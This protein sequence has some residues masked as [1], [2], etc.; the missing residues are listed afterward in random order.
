M[1]LLVTAATNASDSPP[2]KKKDELKEQLYRQ[3]RYNRVQQLAADFR[4]TMS[5]DAAAALIA[6]QGPATVDAANLTAV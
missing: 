4:L 2:K 3:P 1:K 6:L 5:S